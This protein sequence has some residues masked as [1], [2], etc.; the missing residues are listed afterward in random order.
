MNKSI[1]IIRYVLLFGLAM[2]ASA[3]LYADVL[4]TAH[5]TIIATKKGLNLAEEIL[6]QVSTLSVKVDASLPKLIFLMDVMQK[7]SE[8]LLIVVPTIKKSVAVAALAQVPESQQLLASLENLQKTLEQVK[9]S[10]P[11]VR[12]TL[13]EV[14]KTS[15][16]IVKQSAELLEILQQVNPKLQSILN[17]LK[18]TTGALVTT[19]D[20]GKKALDTTENTFKKGWK[21]V[22]KAFRI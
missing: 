10:A 22:E 21:S 6:P 18:S 15:P 13:T 7:T 17:G 19:R 4:D 14:Q 1:A 20:A 2:S 11:E 9:Q 5:E 3:M 16:K 8:Y 12:K